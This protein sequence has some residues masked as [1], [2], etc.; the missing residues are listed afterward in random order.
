MNSFDTSITEDGTDSTA[1]TPN[2]RKISSTWPTLRTVINAHDITSLT[3]SK[4]PIT[5]T[6]SGSTRRATLSRGRLRKIAVQVTRA[7]RRKRRESLAIR[8][9]TRATGVVAAILSKS[10]PFLFHNKIIFDN[11]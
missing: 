11:W 3:T 4:D 2:S 8:R 7:I 6:A 10:L 1:E 5:D 9:E